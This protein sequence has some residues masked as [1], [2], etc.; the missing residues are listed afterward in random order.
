MSR[1][2]RL[3]S[4]D[5][6]AILDEEDTSSLGDSASE[7]EDYQVEDDVQSEDENDYVTEEVLPLQ[8]T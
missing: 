8:S 4:G 7:D 6:L 3:N 5:V 2:K 1:S